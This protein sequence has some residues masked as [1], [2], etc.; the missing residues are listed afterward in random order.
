M[1]GA[2]ERGELAGR[3]SSDARYKRRR[4]RCVRTRYCSAIAELD[5]ADFDARHGVGVDWRDQVLMSSSIAPP[6]TMSTCAEDEAEKALNAN[7]FGG[8]SARPCGADVAGATLVHYSTDFVFDGH[9]NRP[10]VEEDPPNPQSVYAQSKLLGEWFALEA[11]RAF[12]LRVESL[13]GGRMPRARSIELRRPLPKVA[14]QRC[15]A[16][17]SCRRVMS[18]TSRRRPERFWSAA[19]L[20]S[21]TASAPGTPLGTRSGSRSR[22]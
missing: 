19:S 14:R 6:I 18:W 17:G 3:R 4:A 8:Q 11:P 21:T 2:P 20:V 12:V 16:I 15:F 7:A 5:I 22:A 13:F 1:T 9:A 10:Y